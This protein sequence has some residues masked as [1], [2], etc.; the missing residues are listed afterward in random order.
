MIHHKR[1][2]YKYRDPPVAVERQKS[3]IKISVEIGMSDSKVKY[4]A[5]ENLSTD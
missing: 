2:K 3:G 5:R 1:Y 4:T